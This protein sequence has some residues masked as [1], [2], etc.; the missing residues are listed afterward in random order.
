MS[1]LEDH[2][3]YVSMLILHLSHCYRCRT[4][5]KELLSSAYSVSHRFIAKLDT[6]H[7]GGGSPVYVFKSGGMSQ[8]CTILDFVKSLCDIVLFV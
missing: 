5:V 7:G 8:Y 4:W 1:A 3:D 2:L 6:V